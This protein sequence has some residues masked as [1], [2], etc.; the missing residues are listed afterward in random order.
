MAMSFSFILGL[1]AFILGVIGGVMSHTGA[2]R[3]ACSSGGVSSSD[4]ADRGSAR[5]SR[6]T[7]SYDDDDA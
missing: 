2:V 5:V 6:F 4:C 7:V 3:A 1:L